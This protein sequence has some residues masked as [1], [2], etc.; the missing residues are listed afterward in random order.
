MA[1]IADETPLMSLRHKG[2]TAALDLVL[3]IALAW[4][5]V[6]LFHAHFFHP[7]PK[8]NQLEPSFYGPIQMRLK[9]PGTAEKIPE[10]LLV[11]GRPGNASFVYIRLLKNAQARVGVEF[12]GLG[13]FES[14]VFALPAADAQITFQCSIPAFFPNVGDREWLAASL[15]EQAFL[16]THYFLAV[17]GVLRL[18]G[19]IDYKQPPRSLIYIGANPVGGS[20]VSYAF[21]GTILSTSQA[22]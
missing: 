22:K 3:P 14:D 15:R 2:R 7:P 9:L 20:L 17:D 19:S 10:P 4:V 1:A 11:C 5:L 8:F 6:G 12:W 13:A 21:S 16:T 18:T